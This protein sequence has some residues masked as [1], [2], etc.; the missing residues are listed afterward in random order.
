M[1][2]LS[3]L[4]DLLHYAIFNRLHFGAPRLR[5]ALN[6]IKLFAHIVFSQ[7]ARLFSFSPVS[8]LLCCRFCRLL[9]S[10]KNMR[11]K[12]S[13]LCMSLCVDLAIDHQF[14]FELKLL[15]KKERF[16]SLYSFSFILDG[17]STRG[18]HAANNK[19]KTTSTNTRS[20][21]RTHTHTSAHSHT[22]TNTHPRV[23]IHTHT[24]MRARTY[25]LTCA[26]A[27]T[28]PPPHTHTHTHT[29]RERE[30]PAAPL[31]PD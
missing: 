8:S 16:E 2:Q 4:F 14:L 26:R 5:D 12:T 31:R 23:H 7:E 13:C 11:R 28:P 15:V 6:Q 17:K 27:H 29:N 10:K 25:T 3:L 24:H 20:R 22:H 1:L 9:R 30:N 21:A 19:K 18:Y